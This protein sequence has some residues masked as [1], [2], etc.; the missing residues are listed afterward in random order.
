M[1]DSPLEM[2]LVGDSAARFFASMSCK[3]TKPTVQYVFGLYN[4]LE[5][6]KLQS[7]EPWA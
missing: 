6:A 2:N 3:L 5:T 7:R 1:I 4:S